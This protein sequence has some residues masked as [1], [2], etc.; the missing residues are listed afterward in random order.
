MSLP[1]L[2]SSADHPSRFPLFSWY[3]P[4]AR[5]PSPIL[6][7]T[8]QPTILPFNSL[9]SPAIFSRC[10]FSPRFSPLSANH[11]VWRF[12]REYAQSILCRRL[13]SEVLLLLADG[14][15]LCVS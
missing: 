14:I 8:L 10:P 13:L 6:S 5:K 12:P 3:A 2:L 4:A 9:P 1:L 11:P 7:L 15:A